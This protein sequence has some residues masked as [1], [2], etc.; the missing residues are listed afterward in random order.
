[1]FACADSDNWEE[2][3]DEA[4]DLCFSLPEVPSK[5]GVAQSASSGEVSKRLKTEP[6]P[7]PVP[8]PQPAPIDGWKCSL[9]TRINVDEEDRYRA[10]SAVQ[11]MGRV[12]LLPSAC[13]G[14]FCCPVHGQGASAAQCL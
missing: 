4:L 12:L 2:A 8:K 9:C 13:A 3:G 5:A 6:K 1:M 10:C 14:C 7:K 11:C